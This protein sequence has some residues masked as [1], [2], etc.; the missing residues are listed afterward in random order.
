MCTIHVL[1]HIHMKYPCAHAHM[2]KIS[3][4]KRKA[5]PMAPALAPAHP[6]AV[7][8]PVT[9]KSCPVNQGQV[10]SHQIGCEACHTKMLVGL[11]LTCS[12]E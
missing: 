8:I 7:C 12:R 9:P 2:Q 6:S 4:R 1:K 5:E 11:A 10:V 3:A